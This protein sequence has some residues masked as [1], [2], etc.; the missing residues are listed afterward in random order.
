MTTGMVRHELRS[1]CK[2]ALVWGAA[3]AVAAAAFLTVF[4]SLHESGIAIDAIFKDMPE[5]ASNLF[6]MRRDL[7]HITGFYS[8]VLKIVSEIANIGAFVIGAGVMARERRRKT[9]DFL[10]AK[11]VS[12]S[13]VLCSKYIAILAAVF[14][15]GAAFILA[16]TAAITLLSPGEMP[17]PDFFAGSVTI[18][19][20]MLLY[21]TWGALLGVFRPQFKGA[22]AVAIS[23]LI[24]FNS[25]YTVLSLVLGEGSTVYRWLIPHHYFDWI[26][27]LQGGGF[28]W[29]H[30]LWTLAQ[31]AILVYVSFLKYCRKD[32]V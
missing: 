12:R 32:M 23:S 8:M 17:F 22:G 10:F 25:L 30:L 14:A 20:V 15:I 4:P 11:P 26:E 9:E 31:A 3:V 27:L 21:A 2:N 7:S 19:I 1:M 13:A 24:V 5:A 28:D 6:G 29:L 18:P 16:A